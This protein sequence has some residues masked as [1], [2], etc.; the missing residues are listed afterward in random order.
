MRPRHKLQPQRKPR[1]FLASLALHAFLAGLLIYFYSNFFSSRSQEQAHMEETADLPAPATDPENPIAREDSAQDSLI[2]Q[3]PPIR[4]E[5]DREEKITELLEPLEEEVLLEPPPSVSLLENDTLTFSDPEQEPSQAPESPSAPETDYLPERLE[6]SRPLIDESAPAQPEG[7][8]IR[9]QFTTGIKQHEPID[10]LGEIIPANKE[11][12]KRLYYFTEVKN[13]YGKTIIHRW[14]HEGRI[15]AEVP[16]SIDSY[17]WRTYSS[18]ALTPAMMG[19]WQV[20]ITNEQGEPLHTDRFV[21][22]EP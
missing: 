9:A 7:S 4:P 15:I 13:M 22:A 8:I 17:Q 18:K 12:I 21:Y 6:E 16:L 11:G 1:Y 10:R 3:P 5:P 2:D 19:R 20:I 14:E